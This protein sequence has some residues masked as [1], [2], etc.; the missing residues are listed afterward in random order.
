MVG[1]RPAGQKNSGLFAEHRRDLLL[2]PRN[3]TISRKLVRGDPVILCE[4]GQQ[5]RIFG[6]RQRQAIGTKVDAVILGAL[7][8]LALSPHARLL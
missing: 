6:G 3:D 4:A 1:E 8:I 7:R 5:A 2:E